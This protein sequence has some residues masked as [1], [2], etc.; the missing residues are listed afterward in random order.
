MKLVADLES[1][2]FVL[3]PYA[4]CNTN[5]VINGNQMTVGWHV[6]DPKESPI[7]PEEITKFG[8]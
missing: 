7:D 3:N 6:N 5:K 1:I 8:K 4:P 2:G